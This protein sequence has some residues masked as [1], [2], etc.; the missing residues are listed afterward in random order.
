MTNSKHL[1]EVSIINTQLSLHRNTNNILPCSYFIDIVIMV[2]ELSLFL[3]P[4]QSKCYMCSHKP[5]C[6]PATATVVSSLEK[7]LKCYYRFCVKGFTRVLWFLLCCFNNSVLNSWVFMD[8]M[9]S[10]NFFSLSLR[11]LSS[12]SRSAICSICT[13]IINHISIQDG[14][15]MKGVVEGWCENT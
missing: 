15:K 4:S 6:L 10:M 5:S 14:G 7:A 1:F 11:P 12:K 13:Y 3:F 8:K 2:F 9:L